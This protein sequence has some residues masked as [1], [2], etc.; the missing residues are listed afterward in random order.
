MDPATD[1]SREKLRGFLS[2]AA[3]KYRPLT[4]ITCEP[5]RTST[6]ASTACADAFVKICKQS[7]VA[8]KTAYNVLVGFD[9]EN[10]PELN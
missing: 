3:R 5:D 2:S 8:A 6:L 9:I 7:S 10:S 4:V 1:R